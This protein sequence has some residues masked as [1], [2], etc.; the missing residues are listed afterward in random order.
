[1]NTLQTSQKIDTNNYVRTIIRVMGCLLIL[2]CPELFAQGVGIS[3]GGS[4]ITPDASAVLE[5][6]SSARGLLLPRL[7]TG[8]ITSPA[9]GLLIYNGTTTGNMLS[10]YNGS[11]NTLAPVVSP[12][13]TTPTLGV[14]TATSINGLSLTANATGFSIAGG[15]TSKTLTM[16]NTLTLA[17][18]DGTTMTFPT[19]SATIAR[20]DAGNTFTGHQ[21]IEGITS[22][23]ATGS[24]NL[25]FSVSPTFTGTVTHPSPFTLGSTSVTTTGTQ[26]NYLNAA[27]GTTGTASTNVVF[28]T[29]PTITT[30]TLSGVTLSAGTATVDPLTFT[31]G[32][33]LTTAAAGSMEYD[34]TAFYTTPAAASRGVSPS[35]Q[36]AAIQT[37]LT[38][39]FTAATAVA[40]FP[41][42]NDVINIPAA[43]TYFFNGQIILTNTQNTSHT[44]ATG[45]AMGTTGNVISFVYTAVGWTAANNTTVT[46]QNT[47]CVNTYNSTVV[48][49]AIAA[50]N[51][52]SAIT[53]HGIARFSGATTI[54]PQ[55][56]SSATVA[57]TNQ[58][59][60]G[61][62]IQFYP[63]GSSTVTAVGPY[64]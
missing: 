26:L 56:T 32:T 21:T 18:T 13:F 55:I 42:T 63:V 4:V 47:T 16:S 50:A 15:T 61:S 43:G 17:G 6:R 62:Y 48:T 2:C 10:Y 58:V 33:N 36:F 52:V 60:L 9:F 35:I 23:G 39:T 29:S 11:W 51:N 46:A 53:F 54:T 30:P 37:A 44:I 24:G 59:A 49:P 14:A 38:V 34:G 28:S 25:V 31:S 64:N 1:M 12:S 8:S 3:D 7:A 22:T 57:A 5:L 40:W 45:F 19:T 27:T 41:T 20:T